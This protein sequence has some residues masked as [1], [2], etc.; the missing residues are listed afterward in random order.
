MRP[1]RLG[2]VVLSTPVFQVIKEHYPDAKLTVMVKKGVEPLL[3]GLRTVDEILMY[4]PEGR[5]AG[6]RG[7]LQPRGATFASRDF[8]IAV[9]LMSHWKIAAAAYFAGVRYR[10]GPRSKLHSFFF[11]N[12]GL[13]Q[14]R[15]HV[16]MH[17]TDYNLQLLRR[18]G[19]RVGSRSVPTSV[20]V[21]RTPRAR[22]RSSGSRSAAGRRGSR[23]SS[24]IPGWVARL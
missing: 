17:E 12:R 22:R 19:I 16:E 11:Y 15:S 8:R 10:V 2:D 7:F 6:L 18:I 3:A 23:S 4:E 21:S 1:D 13:R 24:S 5:H 20:H 9:V 14:Q